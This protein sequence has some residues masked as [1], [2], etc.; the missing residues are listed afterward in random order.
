MNKA[1]KI[2]ILILFAI[3]ATIIV[4]PIQISNI[5]LGDSGGTSLETIRTSENIYC[6]WNVTND[7]TNVHVTWYRDGIFYYE[8]DYSKQPGNFNQPYG[9]P[10]IDVGDVKTYGEETVWNCTIVAENATS[11]QTASDKITVIYDPEVFISDGGNYQK[12]TRRYNLLE[13]KSYNVIW[14]TT[15][16]DAQTGTFSA[17]QLCTVLTSST[18][19]QGT[20]IGKNGDLGADKNTAG[21]SKVRFSYEHG[22]GSQYHYINFTI[23]PVNDAPNF[24]VT[25]ASMYEN[26]TWNK[27]IKI[28]D[29]EL[30][31]PYNYIISTDRSDFN[32]FCNYNLV[33]DTI[34]FSCDPS[35]TDVGNI[36]IN[37]TVS[38]SPPVNIY[39]LTSSNLTKNFTL[40]IIR[41]NHIPNITYVSDYN[42]TQGEQFTLI[43]N[44]TD[45]Y[46]NNTLNLTITPT[47]NLC[48]GN[49]WSNLNTTQ[50]QTVNSSTGSVNSYIKGLWNATLNNTHI[51][52]R[53]ITIT[54]TDEYG[55]QG[56]YYKYLN[57]T[58]VNDPPIINNYSQGVYLLN[59]TGYYLA[60]FTYNI[61][62]TDPDLL[63]TDPLGIDS[64]TESIVYSIDDSYL[65]QHTSSQTGVISITK[66][67]R[68]NGTYPTR[69]NL[70]DSQSLNYSININ[71]T[72]LPNTAPNFTENLTFI[73]CYEYDSSL[74]PLNC[75]I[76]FSN[77]V[78]DIDPGDSVANITEN[79][80]LFNIT[81][82]IINLRVSQDMV[83]IRRFNITAYDT[84]GASTTKPVVFYLKNTNN[85][86]VINNIIEPKLPNAIYF[87]KTTNT[88]ITVDATDLDEELNVTNDTTNLRYAYENLKFNITNN[89]PGTNITGRIWMNNANK[90]LIVNTTKS[91]GGNLLKTGDYSLNITVT[92]NYYN[93]TNGQKPSQTNEYT[94]NFT[95]YNSTVTPI[96]RKIYPYGNAGITILNTKVITDSEYK[97]IMNHSE[98]RTQVFNV[99]IEDDNPSTVR[100]DWYYDNIKLTNQS[101]INYNS[102]FVL[103]N[104][105]SSITFNFGF[106]EAI[107]QNEANHN[108]TIV[109]ID[110]YDSSEQDTFYWEI[111]VKDKNRPI[112]LNQP[113]PNITLDGPRTK[114]DMDLFECG[115]N[116]GFYDPD[117]D[118]DNNKI[119]D[120]NEP[121]FAPDY[122]FAYNVGS[123]NPK[124]SLCDGFATL[125][126]NDPFYN[127]SYGNYSHIDGHGIAGT[128]E[129]NG[130]CYIYIN[131]TDG[132]FSVVS[133]KI[134]LNVTVV[135]NSQ[136]DQNTVVTKSGTRTVTQVEQVTVPVPEEIDKP[137]Y[138]DIVMPEMVTVYENNSIKIPLRVENTWDKTVYG[139]NLSYET[140]DSLNYTVKFGRHSFYK[141][142]PNETI[143]TSLTVDGYRVGGIYE[144]TVI[145][146]VTDPT[147]K[148]SAKIYLNSIEQTTSGARVR[149]LV[150]FAQDLLNQNKECQ[151]LGEVLKEAQKDVVAGRTNNA[152]EKLESVINGCKFLISKE[153]KIESPKKLRDIHLNIKPEYL[154]YG[155]FGIIEY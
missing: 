19:G 39:N 13:D 129:Q 7:T 142:D 5:W 2:V 38:D 4:Q 71:F 94:Y 29:E 43:I 48:E 72:I 115:K 60:D 26:E 102:S 111:N 83:G 84:R 92:D 99:T 116:Y 150:R 110:G 52:C 9:W 17:N 148:D 146:N 140:N 35:A 1:T 113:I 46:D 23:L 80:N 87:N 34:S 54:V 152:L 134:W 74:Q 10:Y 124:V 88:I 55:E 12:I 127:V 101:A 108:L 143:N 145:A 65:E 125:N 24:N 96:I 133:N 20:C 21:S 139:V 112:V 123:N 61:N 147:Y 105:N 117:L 14:N 154:T 81:N 31:T 137:V 90:K 66:I 3:V 41:V 62:G 56:V 126:L 36:T 53:N 78:T 73:D 18:Y 6:R 28:G 76:N 69:V 114:R 8:K 120:C 63:V 22:A 30:N 27:Q 132:E 49:P 119:L 107:N 141:I 100:Y 91:V 135:D 104:N 37:I 16:N 68:T 89:K 75:T 85:K 118:L 98:N 130:S 15:A 25:N 11:N 50:W 51:A 103:S 57:I 32:S 45:Q 77:Y 106:F 153:Q 70:R 64:F 128:P 95:I 33:G 136:L 40:Q 42:S 155:G 151:E 44:A 149:T 109:A 59:L 144:I 131:A 121:S 86:P 58:N 97:T 93:F 122:T 79:S 138:I 47:S 82:G 67:N